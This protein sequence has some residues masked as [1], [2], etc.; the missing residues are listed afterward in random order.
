MQ[1]KPVPADI[2]IFNLLVMLDL[3]AAYR[4]TDPDD[5]E[6]YPADRSRLWFT[7]INNQGL[8]MFFSSYQV[9]PISEL[10]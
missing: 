5:I 2:G 4:S 3:T 9:K 7:K 8:Q 6:R 1:P 10:K